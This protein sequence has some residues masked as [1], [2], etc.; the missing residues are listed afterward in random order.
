MTG[1]IPELQHQNKPHYIYNSPL[2][3]VE[4]SLDHG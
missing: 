3:A 2:K 4:K 1:V